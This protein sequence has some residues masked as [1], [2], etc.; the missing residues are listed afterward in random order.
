MGNR[1]EYFT[2]ETLTDAQST[3]A[4]GPHGQTPTVAS[5]VIDP[6][7][8]L[9]SFEELLTGRSFDT[10]LNDPRYREEVAGTL[11]SEVAVVRIDRALVH[12]VAQ[13]EAADVL[14]L[15]G[16]WA[17]D[18]EFEGKA[19]LGQLRQFLV[20][21]QQL[22]AVADESGDVYCWAHESVGD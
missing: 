13:S 7:M 20:D 22:C 3:L 11:D 14:K 15:V 8:I 2:A 4:A 10:R 18:D 19:D 5:P 9:G 12:A 16:Q 1:Y 6:V 17:A 21:F